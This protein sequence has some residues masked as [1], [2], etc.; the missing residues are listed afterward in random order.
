V[1]PP[2]WKA[3]L[4]HVR[5]TE[6]HVGAAVVPANL[7]SVEE[8]D[9]APRPIKV[10]GAAGGTSETVTHAIA[11]HTE[12]LGWLAAIAALAL[13]LDVWWVTRQ[14]RNRFARTR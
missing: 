7:T 1:L 14:P 10:D 11:V 12:W 2:L 8:S 13:V 3:G 6:P 5:W 9:I 4:Y